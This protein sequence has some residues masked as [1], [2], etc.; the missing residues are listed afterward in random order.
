MK[1]YQTIPDEIKRTYENLYAENHRLIPSHGKERLH[2]AC[3]YAAYR[4]HHQPRSL[5][6]IANLSEVYPASYIGRTFKSLKL[7]TKIPLPKP[8]EFIDRYCD[9]LDLSVDVIS[10]TKEILNRARHCPDFCCVCNRIPHH[11]AASA[12][13][14]A[15]ILSGE[16]RTQEELFETTLVTT[17]AIRAGYKQIAEKTD[18]EIFL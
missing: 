12:V 5:D 18:I 7:K 9:A 4:I 6:E 10:T 2:Y 11:V 15:S 1:H 17:S 3:L 16:R 8:E 13:Y 14:I